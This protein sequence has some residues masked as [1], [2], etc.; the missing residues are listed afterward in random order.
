M[1][2]R[3][4]RA[5]LRDAV[6]DDF[7][8]TAYGKGLRR[9]RARDQSGRRDGGDL[10]HERRAHRAGLQRARRR[11]LRHAR[12]RAG[13][14]AGAIMVVLANTAADLITTWLDPRLRTARG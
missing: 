9:R 4:L 2:L 5:A 8:R 11:P 12:L 3:V 13:R 14:P 7:V 1:V 10:R 6:E